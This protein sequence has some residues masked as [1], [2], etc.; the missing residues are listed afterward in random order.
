MHVVAI[1]DVQVWSSMTP[2][3]LRMISFRNLLIV[4]LKV[5]EVPLSSRDL[6]QALMASL[7]PIVFHHSALARITPPVQPLDPS[8]PARRYALAHRYRHPHLHVLGMGWLAALFILPEVV[9]RNAP[10][11]R[12]FGGNGGTSV[13]AQLAVHPSS[14]DDGRQYL[15]LDEV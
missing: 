9:A 10:L 8:N 2:A 1:K 5:F 6:R 13:W 14:F 12:C 4:R 11:R 7:A 3:Q 15:S